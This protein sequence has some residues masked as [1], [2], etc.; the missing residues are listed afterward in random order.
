MLNERQRLTKRI[1]DAAKPGANRYTIWD[2]VVPG[3]GLRITST[4]T[5]TFTLRYRARGRRAQKR[6]LSIGRYGVLT[7]EEARVMQGKFSALSRVVKIQ[8]E[9]LRIIARQALFRRSR[10]ISCRR[11]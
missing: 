11:M 8:P 10:M 7:V 6:Y 3:F 9:R 5:K 4:G 1:V 2:A